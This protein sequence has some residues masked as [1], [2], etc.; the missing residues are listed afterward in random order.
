M[1]ETGKRRGGK[2][3]RGSR[4][5]GEERGGNE[6]VGAVH[7]FRCCS[8]VIAPLVC[9]SPLSSSRHCRFFSVMPCGENRGVGPAWGGSCGQG[10]A[11]VLG[12]CVSGLELRCAALSAGL[13]SPLLSR[14][15]LC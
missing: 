9:W 15:I 6:C 4:G 14:P 2:W 8:A 13:P 12:L 7:V 11:G 1:V 3:G 5:Q 10:C